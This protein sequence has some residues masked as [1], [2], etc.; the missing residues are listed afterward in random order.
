MRAI[1]RFLTYLL[2]IGLVASFQLPATAQ[3]STT[4]PAAQATPEAEMKAAMSAARLIAVQGP[5]D[6]PLVDQAVLHLSKNF[7]F[8]P[9]K[10]ARMILKAMG[11]RPVTK[12]S[13]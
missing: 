6:I 1:P 3:Q 4:V 11:N 5:A 7:V 2:V 13:A 12:C 9:A 10:E 8:V